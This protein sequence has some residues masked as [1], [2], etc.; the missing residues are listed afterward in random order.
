[1]EQECTI[2][3]GSGWIITERGGLSGAKR[4]ECVNRGRTERLLDRAGIPE[5]YQRVT[6]IDDFILPK[7]NPTLRAG[8]AAVMTGVR[9]YVREF[10]ALD[11]L[12]L[13]FMGPP[14][15]GK[16]HL[17]IAVLRELI[18][19]GHEGVFFNY[20]TLLQRIHS[21]YDKESG[22]SDREAFRTA[23]D[24]EIL[25]LDD[26]GSHRVNDWVED[27]MTSIITA[28]CDAKKPLIVTTNLWDET[29]GDRRGSGV[30]EGIYSKYFLA[31]RV[32]MRARSRLFEMCS[33]I[34]M[35]NDADYRV[36]NRKSLMLR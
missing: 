29:A 9:A 35:P 15:T 36:Q 18:K 34:R 22:A 16:T 11:R 10:P 1:M 12:G 24:T 25:V 7:D 26:L 17:A 4:C 20:Q 5:N 13:L 32:G 2:C 6:S 19:K 30:Q 8:L 23:L 33:V 28:R 14:G 21:G 3:G 31:E 27:T